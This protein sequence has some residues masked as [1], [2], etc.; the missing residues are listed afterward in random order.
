MLALVV[1]S[2]CSESPAVRP[3]GA[4]LFFFDD[5]AVTDAAPPRPDQGPCSHPTV[6]PACT[7]G[8]CQ[9][10]AGCFTMGTP[11]G[12]PCDGLDEPPHSVYI[13]HALLIEESEVTQQ[14]FEAALGYAPALHGAC[15]TCPV[16]NVSWHEA[17]AYCN[18]RST[19][20]TLTPCYSCSGSGKDVL[21]LPVADVLSC[22]GFRLPTE[23]EWEYAARGGKTEST[24]AGNVT[25][26]Q[27][28]DTVLDAIS[29]YDANAGGET[30][31]VGE[32]TA[33][34]W[35]L[36]DMLGNVNEWTND[37]LSS[38]PSLDFAADP[39]GPKVGS[40][41]VIRGGSWSQA[42]KD[43]RAANRYG[44]SPNAR[45]AEL[46]FRCLRRLP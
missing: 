45:S 17:A 6:T 36:S 37:W 35:G 40:S 24:Y 14:A 32:K 19:Q 5:A 28:P 15:P 20:A 33:N 34:P 9:I 41:K 8:L 29:W 13:T 25:I 23:A 42:P 21:C 1:G 7:N 3:S 27:A 46:G 43:A 38:D 22:A 31:P 4:D 10:P 26:C 30:H 2:A 12:Q 16:E 18:K 39:L 11:K 44:F